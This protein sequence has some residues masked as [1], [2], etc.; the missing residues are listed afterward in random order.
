MR[1]IV[2]DSAH[3]VGIRLAEAPP[4][5]PRASEA[6]VRVAAFTI[7]YGDIATAQSLPDGAVPGWEAAGYVAQAAADGS[8]PGVGT[9]VISL[10]EAGGWA[11]YRAVDTAMLG[12]VPEA[13]D[14]GEMSTLP[15]AANS[16]LRA[17]RRIGPIL[18]RTVMVT[19]AT[20][21]VGR[22]AVQLAYLGGA[23][24]VAVTTSPDRYGAE[25]RCLGAS[26]VV[27]SPGQHRGEVHGVID[28]VGGD[29]L[30][31][32]FDRLGRDGVLVALGHVTSQPE[33][34]PVGTL[35]ADP[36][37]HNRSIVTFHQLDGSP[38]APDLAWLSARLVEGRLRPSIAWRGPWTRVAEVIERLHSGSLHGK[39]VVDVP[40]DE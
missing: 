17:L 9:P 30:V 15:V 28:C 25:L 4:P 36:S 1:A 34:F 35:I 29:L 19:G 10:G 20:G 39:A 7:N 26:D 3:P 23:T 11:E 5:Q 8:G 21:G 24:V 12:V 14:L 18:G 6:V 37:R 33:V 32:A 27:A 31:Q 40:A 2:V 16:A 22:Y 38:L 13:A